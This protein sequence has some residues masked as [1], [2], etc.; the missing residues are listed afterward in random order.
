MTRSFPYNDYD[1]AERIQWYDYGAGFFD[2]ASR[3][4]SIYY[5]NRVNHY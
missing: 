3:G 5:H 1:A 2:P 4:S